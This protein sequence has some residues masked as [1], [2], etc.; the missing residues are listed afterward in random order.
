M[1]INAD[2]S[3]RAVVYS[4]ELPWVNSPAPAVTQLLV[5]RAVS[6]TLKA[7]TYYPTSSNNPRVPRRYPGNESQLFVALHKQ[8]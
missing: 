8:K 1:K 7:V 2:L 6:F 4:E 5:L 3:Q